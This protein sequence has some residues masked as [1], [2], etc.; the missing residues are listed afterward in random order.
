MFTK[1]DNMHIFTSNKYESG[2]PQ[3]VYTRRELGRG[4]FYLPLFLF[5][6]YVSQYAYDFLWVVRFPRHGTAH[7]FLLH[8]GFSLQSFGSIMRI[9][10]I[11]ARHNITEKDKI[12]TFLGADFVFIE[13]L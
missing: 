8:H 12:R 9:Q 1:E 2:Q 11:L 4:E 7:F 5:D 3:K 6:F 13:R 10:D